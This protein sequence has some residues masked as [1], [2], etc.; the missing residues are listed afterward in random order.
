[1][2]KH[3]F[4]ALWLLRIVQNSRYPPKNRLRRRLYYSGKEKETHGQKPVYDKPEWPD[5]YKTKH[6]QI[7][8]RHDYMIYKDNHPKLPNEVA[9]MYDGFLGVEDDYPEQKSSLPFKKEKGCE[10]IVQQK[11]YNAIILQRG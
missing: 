7:G 11:E 2:L 8:K 1:M 6:K 9:S 10:L 4:R 5:I 3:T